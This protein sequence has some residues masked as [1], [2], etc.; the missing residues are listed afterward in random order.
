M[1]CQ[2]DVDKSLDFSGGLLLTDVGEHLPQLMGDVGVIYG[3]TKGAD[4][5]PTAY[6]Y[7]PKLSLEFNFNPNNFIL[8]PKVSYEYHLV[9]IGA[10]ISII[11]FI[12]FSQH[13]FRLT[14]EAGI[15]L[16]GGMNLFY[17]Y[18]IPI[19]DNTLDY[20]TNHRLSLTININNVFD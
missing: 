12:N 16:N 7:G 13:D 5:C 19:T 14:P 20:I 9:L 17:G 8:A 1:F 11:D 18:N 6:Y 10:R 2:E 4:G 3:T 15:S